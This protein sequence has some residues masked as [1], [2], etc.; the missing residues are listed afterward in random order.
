[1]NAGVGAR[2]VSV[3]RLR[4]RRRR[5]QHKMI[6]AMRPM[7]KSG[8]AMPITIFAHNGRPLLPSPRAL[9][10][11]DGEAVAVLTAE[12][13]S[14]AEAELDA[15]VVGPNSPL[16]YCCTSVGSAVNQ[17]GVLSSRNS[18]HS[19]RDT[20]GTLVRARA[21]MDGGTAVARSGNRSTL[22][23]V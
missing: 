7:T 23:D 9:P 14:V 12:D 8:T 17:A 22:G 19:S 13:A 6:P 10:R 1:M 2:E 16:K 4:E 11:A 5:Q 15:I 3:S 18:D 20:A 21:R